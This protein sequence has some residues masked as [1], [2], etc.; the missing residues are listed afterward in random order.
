MTSAD[1][2]L[3]LLAAAAIGCSVGL[4][5]FAHHRYIGVRTLGLVALGAAALVAAVLESGS[6]GDQL[7]AASR[8]IQGIVTGIGFIGAGVIVQ[9]EQRHKVHGLTTAATVWVSA[10]AGIVCGLGA[11]RVAATVVVLA[12][13]VLLA[14]GRVERLLVAKYGA[15]PEPEPRPTSAALQRLHDK[16]PPGEN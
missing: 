10:A 3:R 13:I 16:A 12:S 6:G 8:V 4:N 11:W 14:G 15:D 2:I 9:R 7:Q 5:R 1:I